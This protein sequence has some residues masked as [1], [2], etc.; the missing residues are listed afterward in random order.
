MGVKASAPPA[1]PSEVGGDLHQLLTLM[2]SVIHGLKQAGGPPPAAF[3]EAAARLEADPGHGGL[4]PR[5]VPLLLMV[6]LER[7]RSVSELAARLGLSVSTVSLMV[8][9]LSRAG[10]LERTEDARDRRR[11]LVRLHGDHDAEVSAWMQ[12][13]IAPVRRALDRLSP[14]ARAHF[15]DGWRVLAEEVGVADLGAG[16]CE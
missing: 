14:D 6:A 10:L 15:L 5:H 12:Q 8:G 16:P 7:D 4:G 1:D 3:A 9:E 2:S 11:T 13:R